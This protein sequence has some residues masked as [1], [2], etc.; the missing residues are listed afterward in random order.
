MKIASHIPLKE[1]TT[2]DDRQA[3]LSTWHSA[4]WETI[5]SAS[6]G[7][8]IYYPSPAYPLPVI[9]HTISRN[10]RRNYPLGYPS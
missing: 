6:H 7:E 10:D 5:G 4:P 1:E 2:Q 8:V 9:T 3:A